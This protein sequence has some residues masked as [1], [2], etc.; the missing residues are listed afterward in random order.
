MIGRCRS[1]VLTGLAGHVIDVEAHVA[2]GLP[3]FTIVGL[4]DA[5]LAEAKDRVRAAVASSGVEWPRQ[6]I[7]VNLSPASLPKS[8]PATDL[9]IAVAVLAAA[10]TVDAG[11]AR[12]LVLLGEL[13]LDGRVRPVRGVLP[14][15]AAAVDA[16]ATRVVVPAGNAA[17]AALVSGAQVEGA[18]A[19]ATVLRALGADARAESVEPVRAPAVAHARISPPDLADVRGQEAARTALEVAA[20]GGHHLLM[21]GPP[22][23]G[24][25]M[26]AERLPGIL[27]DLDD[28]EAVRVT[29]VHSLAGAF[30]PADGL[31]RRPPFEAPHH[32]ASSA[33]IVG[34]GAGLARPG[35]V[36]LAHAGVLFLDEAP[37]FPTRVL[38]TLRQPLERGEIVL[39]RA[40][41]ATR[42]PARFQLVLAA[43]PCPCGRFAG[44]GEGCS[45]API[46]RRRYLSRL[47]GPLLDRIDIQVQVAAAARADEPGEPS[48]AVAARVAEARAAATERLSPRGWRVSAEVPGTWLR[49]ATSRAACAG[50]WRAVDRGALTARGFDRA[51]RLAWT[52]ADL[53]GVASPGVDHVAEALALRQGVAA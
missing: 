18:V 6:R 49:E 37:E 22:G 11:R 24:K 26:L 51:L 8:G 19:L 27:P 47:S 36:S 39:H 1:V 53:E 2:R 3:A 10:R 32:T 25:T 52:L 46:A 9:A 23:A 4:P 30:D 29:A 41:G 20:A 42:Y 48:V 33:A 43:N 38:D 17:E 14:A 50:L 31:M 16:G 5:S 40:H 21:L 34:G 28:A 13:G 35:A 44:T 12:E 45:C 15:V 7:T